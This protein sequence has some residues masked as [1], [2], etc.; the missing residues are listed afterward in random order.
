MAPPPPNPRAKEAGRRSA[1]SSAIGSS[2]GTVQT[3]KRDSMYVEARELICAQNLQLKL[4]EKS[5]PLASF[6]VGRSVSPQRRLPATCYFCYRSSSTGS[7]HNQFPQFPLRSS[8]TSKILL[9]DCGVL[10]YKE[11]CLEGSFGEAHLKANLL[12]F[13]PGKCGI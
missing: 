11:K 3:R 1:W 10:T 7:R 6:R 9:K 4:F 5:E 2:T 13:L 12:G 8:D